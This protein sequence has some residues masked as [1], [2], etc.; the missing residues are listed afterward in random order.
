[1]ENFIHIKYMYLLDLCQCFL[2]NGIFNVMNLMNVKGKTKHAASNEKL[3]VTY[4][5]WMYQTR[6]YLKN[7]PKLKFKYLAS[8][9]SAS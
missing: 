1:M 6:V 3:C 5:P 4:I 7:I 2:D 8:K 9:N